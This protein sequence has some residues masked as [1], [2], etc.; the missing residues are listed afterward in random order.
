VARPAGQVS[1]LVRIGA[2][3]V[4]LLLPASIFDEQPAAGPD[5]D[6]PLIGLAA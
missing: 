5:R 6:E 2:Q 3:A 4:Q 1:Q